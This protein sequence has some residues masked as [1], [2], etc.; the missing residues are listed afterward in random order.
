[1]VST[2]KSNVLII[3]HPSPNEVRYGADFISTIEESPEKIFNP[4]VNTLVIY[5]QPAL[6][7]L[8]FCIPPGKLWLKENNGSHVALQ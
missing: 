2:L 3:G 4:L 7:S 5:Y 8:E 1:M 6:F